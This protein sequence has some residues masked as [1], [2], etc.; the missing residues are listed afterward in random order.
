MA[1][2][3]AAHGLYIQIHAHH[4][5]PCLESVDTGRGVAQH[6]A[7][8]A[9]ISAFGVCPLEAAHS[10]TIVGQ[11]AAALFFD[12]WRCSP[13]RRRLVLSGTTRCACPTKPGMEELASAAHLPSQAVGKPGLVAGDPQMGFLMYRISGETTFRS[14]RLYRLWRR[15]NRHQQMVPDIVLH[16]LPCGD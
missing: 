16:W 6:L 12:A 8:S 11:S 2:R 10:D 15:I 13:M 4:Q 3:K 9:Q 5:R 14:L 1:H 7:S